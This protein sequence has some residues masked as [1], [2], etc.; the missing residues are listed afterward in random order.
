MIQIH[1]PIHNSHLPLQK[2]VFKLQ[3]FSQPVDFRYTSNPSKGVATSDAQNMLLTPANNTFIDTNNTYSMKKEKKKN[4]CW[5]SI[6]QK[7]PHHGF[8]RGLNFSHFHFCR[9]NGGG[10]LFPFFLTRFK[11]NLTMTDVRLW[12]ITNNESNRTPLSLILNSIYSTGIYSS[13]FY[14]QL[15]SIMS[16]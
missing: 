12:C 2:N 8:L 11:K 15:P 4:C 16:F 1:S 6:K 7:N 3:P 14:T 10:R 5:V 9:C 13:S